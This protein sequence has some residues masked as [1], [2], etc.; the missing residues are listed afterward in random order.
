MWLSEPSWPLP[1]AF[2]PVRGPVRHVNGQLVRMRIEQRWVDRQ[3]AALPKLLTSRD[4]GHGDDEIE[5]LRGERIDKQCMYANAMVIA[6]AEGQSPGGQR[7]QLSSGCPCDAT[8]RRDAVCCAEVDPL[9]HFRIA[10]DSG[11]DYS[12]ATELSLWSFAF[13]HARVIRSPRACLRKCRESK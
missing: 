8:L 6:A 3:N 9:H 5:L 2:S 7:A 11:K 4:S 1:V 13:I 10:Q 12:N